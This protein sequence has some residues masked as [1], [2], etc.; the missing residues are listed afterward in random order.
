MQ[1]V[2]GHGAVE[3]EEG[4]DDSTVWTCSSQVIVADSIDATFLTTTTAAT[5]TTVPLTTAK[6]SGTARKDDAARGARV[7]EKHAFFTIDSGLGRL[8]MHPEKMASLEEATI[9]SFEKLNMLDK[10]TFNG[11]LFNDK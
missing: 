6:L 5:A 3:D 4:G 8:W 2:D 9:S 11:P 1:Q 10:T 7:E